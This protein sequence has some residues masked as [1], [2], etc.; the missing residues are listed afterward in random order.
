MEKIVSHDNTE[1]SIEQVVETYYSN[2]ED[3][4]ETSARKDSVPDEYFQN[5]KITSELHVGSA[6]D[7]GSRKQNPEICKE[8]FDDHK[9]NN[10]LFS[11]Y[12]CEGYET[13]EQD[14]YERHVVIKHPKKVAYPGKAD[15]DSLGLQPKGKD[16][17]RI[18]L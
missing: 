9:S 1:I 16:W 13:N 14:D 2:P 5:R 15:L 18:G 6:N 3:Y 7:M 10:F 12:Y 17:E 8:L 4:F 11:C